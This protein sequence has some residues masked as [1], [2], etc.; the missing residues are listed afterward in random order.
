MQHLKR[1]TSFFKVLLDV[2]HYAFRTVTWT[3]V[4]RSDRVALKGQKG[5]QEL[6]AES[7][8]IRFETCQDCIKESTSHIA[9]T[10]LHTAAVIR[11]TFD[12]IRRFTTLKTQI[13]VPS[14]ASL[15][16]NSI[17]HRLHPILDSFGTMASW[18][19]TRPQKQ[20]HKHSWIIKTTLF[21]E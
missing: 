12:P 4:N 21:N 9:T 19:G 3:I 13:T 8:H 20:L 14:V 15:I 1:F 6:C 18:A 7:L 5:V 16:Y 10:V 2:A 11:S 17:L